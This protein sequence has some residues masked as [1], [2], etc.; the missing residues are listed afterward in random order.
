MIIETVEY[1]NHKIN[2]FQDEC[3]SNPCE[4]FDGLGVMWCEHSH[5]NLGHADAE[6]TLSNYC[7]QYDTA[8]ARKHNQGDT[9]LQDV[10]Q[11]L[12]KLKAVI[13]SLY[14]YDHSGI[15]MRCEPFGCDW[16]SGQVGIIVV[17]AH[18]MRASFNVKKVTK[19][20]R[21]KAKK[22]LVGQVELYDNY[23]TGNVYGFDII[24]DG[25]SVDSCVGFYGSDYEKSGLIEHA[26]SE[27]DYIDK[28]LPLEFT[29]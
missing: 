23:L 29:A 27:I 8:Y 3:A 20:I 12:E 2:I 7:Y 10:I 16:D 13:L 22:C 21:E 5:Y 11:S 9:C 1:R 6:N 19:K 18:N 4:E 26:R 14:L 25:E 17:T 15:T 24:D 28:Q